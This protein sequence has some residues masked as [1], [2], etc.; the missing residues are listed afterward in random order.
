MPVP[1]QR[2]RALMLLLALTAAAFVLAAGLA[3][4]AMAADGAVYTQTND[5]AGNTVQRFERAEDGALAAAGTFATGGVGP[6]RAGRPPGRRRALRRQPVALRRQRRLGHG[7]RLP[8]GPDG[9]RSPTRSPSGGAA[10]TSVD[11]CRGRVYVL[12]SGGDGQRDRVRPRVDGTLRKIG[13]AGSRPRRGRCRAGV[14]HAER[15]G[16]LVSERLSN[17]LETLPLERAGRPGAPVVN[18]SSGAV[19]FGFGITRRGTIVVSEAGASTVSSYRLGA[20]GALRR[21][22][23]ARRSA[24]ARRAGSPSPRRAPRLYRQR[25]GQHQRL[26]VSPDGALSALDANGLTAPI[27]SPRDLDFDASGR[28]LVR[29]VA[30]QRGHRRPGHGVPRRR[31]TAR[32]RWPARH[33]RSPASR[34]SRPPDHGQS[35]G[36]L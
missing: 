24:R 35:R 33:P 31:P 1:Y 32:S 5:P 30:G 13:T 16:A 17:R 22:C 11:G 10:P 8:R 4:S 34:A 15:H 27:Q 14:G 36:R 9:S 21:L 28:F 3:S 20:A 19:P 6:G 7:V 26:R 18:A 29:R 2:P 12:N 25:V 23:L